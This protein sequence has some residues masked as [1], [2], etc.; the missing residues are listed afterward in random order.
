MTK[1]HEEYL[2]GTAGE[3]LTCLREKDKIKGE[4]TILINL[5]KSGKVKK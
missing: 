3:L 2:S 4:I 5:R 1:I